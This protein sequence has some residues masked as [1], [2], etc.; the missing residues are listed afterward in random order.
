M[1]N[2][3][4]DYVFVRYMGPKFVIAFSGV[5]ASGVASFLNEMKEKVENMQIELTEEERQELNLEVKMS[6]KEPKGASCKEI[7]M[8]KLNFVISS[9]YKGTGLEEVLKKLEEYLDHA[10]AQESDITNI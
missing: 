9:Y 6:G 3:S 10:D 7:A 5:E 8:P 4:Q 2:L 1:E